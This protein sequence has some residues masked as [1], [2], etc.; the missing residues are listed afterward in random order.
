MCGTC[1]K[2]FHLPDALKQHQ[3][4][5]SHTTI[6]FAPLPEENLKAFYE[7]GEVRETGI[8]SPNTRASFID[9]AKLRFYI[10]VFSSISA[11]STQIT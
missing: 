3:E 4:A 10:R 11:K 7:K 1:N 2:I 9:G 5:T 8:D 6:I